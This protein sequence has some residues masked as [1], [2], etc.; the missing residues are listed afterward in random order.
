MLDNDEPNDINNKTS[1][2]IKTLGKINSKIE[3]IE[4]KITLINQIYIQYEFNKNLKL[5]QAN[6]YLKFQIDFLYY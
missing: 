6:S 4:K 5:D 1:Y 3:E 2:I